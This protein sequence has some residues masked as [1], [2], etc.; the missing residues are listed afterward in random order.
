MTGLTTAQLLAA[1]LVL[2]YLLDSMHFLCLDE[3]VLRTRGGRLATL[4]FGSGLELGGRRP[5]LPNP[6]TPH[7]PEFRLQLDL[8]TASAA[9]TPAAE[10]DASLRARLAAVA[11]LRGLSAACALLT[12]LAA[13]A[14][15]LAGSDAGFLLVVACAWLLM[16]VAGTLALRA[17]AALGLGT[18]EV[19]GMAVIALVCLPCAGNFTRALLAR[20]RPTLDATALLQLP[21]ADMDE[22]ARRSVLRAALAR[23]RRR[24]TEDSRA[25]RTLDAELARLGEDHP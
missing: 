14:A 1:G 5:F 8:A 19:L 13:P 7:R 24:T 6:F 4:S 9:A 20:P 12:V 21:L 23:L 17:R 18:G 10:I 3:A 15:L 25:A 2:V 11:V 22:A 16:L